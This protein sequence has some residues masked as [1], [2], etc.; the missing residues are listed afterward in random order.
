MNNNNDNNNN[1]N[2]S[3]FNSIPPSLNLSNTNNNVSSEEGHTLSLLA[4]GEIDQSPSTPPILKTKNKRK[5]NFQRASVAC[6]QCRKAKTRCNYINDGSNC[7]RCENL[8]LKCSLMNQKI[9]PTLSNF[10]KSANLT[11][12]DEV[13][14]KKLTKRR[15]RMKPLSNMQPVNLPFSNNLNKTNNENIYDSN[16]SIKSELNEP[17]N[18]IPS[19][20]GNPSGTE[21]NTFNLLNIV[22]NK[23]DTLSSTLNLLINEKKNLLNLNDSNINNNNNNLNNNSNTN[24]N[25]N[26]TNNKNTSNIYNHNNTLPF[27]NSGFQS[28]QR[29]FEPSALPRL[30]STQPPIP[31]NFSLIASQSQQNT[32]Q[33]P[34]STPTAFLPSS[35]PSQHH[36]LLSPTII[37]PL[38]RPYIYA[39][40]KLITN[41]YQIP[42]TNF[43]NNNNTN[44][45]V[46]NTTQS[47]NLSINNNSSAVHE[48]DEFF[49]LNAPY[50]DV[51]NISS[52]IG[53]PFSKEIGFDI[54]KDMVLLS[55]QE[56]YDL[57]NRKLLDYETCYRLIEI[58]LAH[59][60]KWITYDEV[61]FKSWFDAIRISSPLLF[62]T[63]VLF[64]LRHY[65]LNNINKNL[66]LDILQS[67]HQL[68]SL[69]IYEVPQSKEFLQTTILLTHYSPSLSYKHIYFDSWW[70]SSYGLIHF[71]TREMTMNLLVKSVKSSEKIHQY[72]LWNHLTISHLINCILSGRPCIIDE[73]RLDQCRDILDLQEANS[74]D[75]I[76]VAELC[77]ILSLYNSLQFPEEIDISMKELDSIYSDWK[78]LADSVLLGGVIIGFYY[79]AKMMILR[80]FILKNLF[81]KGKSRFNKRCREFFNY[82]ITFSNFIQTRNEIYDS[83]DCLKQCSFLCIFMIL[84]FKQLDLFNE[85]DD[86]LMILKFVN[87]FLEIGSL[88]ESKIFCFNGYYSHYSE[89]ILRMKNMVF[90]NTQIQS[91]Q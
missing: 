84:Q 11:T 64:G 85:P 58:A 23:I 4:D 76:I 83:S 48:N 81:Q 19:N 71:M 40:N 69:S 65:R 41:P 88:L 74:F 5:Y 55:I 67:I 15:K 9:E 16:L 54:T 30:Y 3:H 90:P 6:E 47:N 33:Q 25:N 38:A 63:L 2:N 75:A 70:I 59:Y 49:F 27:Y 43:L 57:I 61:D 56:R 60:G 7:F 12:R 28:I 78:Y 34:D 72:R 1:N 26:N 10:Q 77:I 89:L 44:P 79:F 21:L 51:L 31:S 13:E 45:N 42:T 91:N 36:S 46:K 35:H 22:N 24:N 73:I 52:I 29:N 82:A 80:R 14:E 62:C 50:L 68:L 86:N 37:A 39:T 87:T 8:S 66:E 53:L 17:N 32:N 18:F 20:I